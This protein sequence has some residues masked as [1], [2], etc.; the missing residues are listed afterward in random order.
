MFRKIALSLPAFISLYTVFA[1]EITYPYEHDLKGPVQA[2]SEKKYDVSFAGGQVQAGNY[3]EDKHLGIRAFDRQGKLVEFKTQPDEEGKYKRTVVTYDAGGCWMEIREFGK[4]EYYESSAEFTCDDK[5]RVIQKIEFDYLNDES[6]NSVTTY[7]YDAAGHITGSHRRWGDP[8]RGATKSNIVFVQ[9]K[10][11]HLYKTYDQNGYL[12]KWSIKR[13][14]ID[15]EFAALFSGEAE[16]TNDAK[17]RPIAQYSLNDLAAKENK[18]KQKKLSREMVYN[19][20][21]FIA[22]QVEYNSYGKPDVTYYDYT[23]DSH[24]NWI[25]KTELKATVKPGKANATPH[26]IYKREISYY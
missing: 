16:I 12:V 24:G 5:G 2:C 3:Q 18:S 6:P 14:G 4:K 22:Q 23:Y 10:Y 25:T 21:G 1:Q 17:G 11:D 19:A 26:L 20:E 7:T 15:P 9:D 13:E 8:K